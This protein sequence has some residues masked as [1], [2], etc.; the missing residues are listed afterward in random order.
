MSGTAGKRPLA[1]ATRPPE[2][3]TRRG[4]DRAW[5]TP[6]QARHIVAGEAA[7]PSGHQWVLIDHADP[8]MLTVY[9]LTGKY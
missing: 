2:P 9:V 5:W 7:R 6:E 1:P 8:R 3:M 4:P